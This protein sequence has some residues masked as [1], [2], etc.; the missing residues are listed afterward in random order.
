MPADS[1]SD[2]AEGAAPPT[3]WDETPTPIAYVLLPEQ[4]NVV[5][6]PA[7]SGELRVRVEDLDGKPVK[8]QVV[9]FSIAGEARDSGLSMLTATTDKNGEAKNEVLGGAMEAGFEVVVSL[10]G[11]ESVRV[12]VMVYPQGYG[13]LHVTAPYAGRHEPQAREIVVF[14]EAQCDALPEGDDQGT[15]VMLASGQDDATIY[16]AAGVE[17]AVAATALGTDDSALA[18]ACTDGVMLAADEQQDLALAFEDAALNISGTFEL[19]LEMDG[20]AAAAYVAETLRDALTARVSEADA[21]VAAQNEAS[22]LLAALTRTLQ[23]DTVVDSAEQTALDEALMAGTLATDLQTALEADDLG[24]Q[25]AIAALTSRVYDSLEVLTLM[26]RMVADPDGPSASLFPLSL[27]AGPATGASTSPR[28]ELSSSDSA[29]PLEHDAELDTVGFANWEVSLPVGSLATQALRDAVAQDDGS[30]PRS[31]LMGCD[32]MFA[33]FAQW[34]ETAMPTT[35]CGEDCQ[36][37]ACD[38]AYANLVTAAETTMGTSAPTEDNM[39]SAVISAT[40][41]LV[42][43]NGDLMPDTL[44]A[45]SITVQL[46]LPEGPVDTSD[47]LLNTSPGAMAQEP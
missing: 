29:L 26:S 1:V 34:A 7:D 42:D 31:T 17:Y 35:V 23:V 21:G 37:A 38:R 40:L 3:L 4:D 12:P 10:E 33:V 9:S 19:T 6:G 47:A 30:D 11:A 39:A 28:V 8:G 2:A 22:Y 27:M 14:P 18:Q 13:S 36:R 25:A 5:L 24:P 46:T 16:L 15:R 45:E 32:A 44:Q 20:N 41:Q 43:E